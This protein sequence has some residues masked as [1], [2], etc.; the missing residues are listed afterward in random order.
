MIEDKIDALC[1]VLKRIAAA[2]ENKPPAP[3]V[4]SCSGTGI[5][6][7]G[8][9]PKETVEKV[10]G[11]TAINYE[12]MDHPTLKKIWESRGNETPPRTRGATIAKW[13]KNDDALRAANQ[14]VGTKEPGKEPEVVED[15]PFTPTEEPIVEVTDAML[16]TE[17]QRVMAIPDK[18]RDEV[19]RIVNEVG[20]VS[21]VKLIPNEKR[22]AVLQAAKA[23]Q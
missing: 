21:Q 8:D 1:E 2:L 5:G 7:N 6:G 10:T 18:G 12:D 13:L 15:D 9:A 16:K 14:N 19:I 11:S 17:L 4:C 22:A 23:V 20:G 3:V